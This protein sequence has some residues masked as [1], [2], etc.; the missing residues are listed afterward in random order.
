MIFLFNSFP[1]IY[2]FIRNLYR[3][4]SLAAAPRS[5]TCS[6]ITRGYKSFANNGNLHSEFT[7]FGSRLPF[8]LKACP[9]CVQVIPNF[10]TFWFTSLGMGLFKWYQ[11]CMIIIHIEPYRFLGEFGDLSMRE[12]ELGEDGM[13]SEVRPASQMV[14]LTSQE[15]VQILISFVFFQS[16]PP[17][18]FFQF[19]S[20][21][22]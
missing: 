20:R 14:L 7:P 1:Y 19:T 6:R 8:A 5:Q 16:C 17:I 13:Y 9:L 3:S 21:T 11:T 2:W 22:F 4:E 12:K 18:K 15:I 10:I